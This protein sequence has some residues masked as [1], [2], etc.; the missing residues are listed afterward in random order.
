V[1][2]PHSQKSIPPLPL[3]VSAMRIKK[4]AAAIT[5]SPSEILSLL[6]LLLV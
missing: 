5:A 2:L 1:F 6:V 3:L 4:N